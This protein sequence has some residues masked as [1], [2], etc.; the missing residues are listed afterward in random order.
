MHSSSG[1]HTPEILDNTRRSRAV[2]SFRGEGRTD[3]LGWHPECL[4]DLSR[5]AGYLEMFD[6]KEE[7]EEGAQNEGESEMKV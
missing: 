6:S 5:K 3:F 7:K 4:Q 2:F 1:V